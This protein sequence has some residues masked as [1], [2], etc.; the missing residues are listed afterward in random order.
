MVLTGNTL[1]HLSVRVTLLFKERTPGHLG[2]FF[3]FAHL[4]E[5][6][7]G[8]RLGGRESLSVS[9]RISSSATELACGLGQAPS[10]PWASVS[11]SAQ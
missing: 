9:S 10:P 8:G 7:G 2:P 5:R 6:D 1:V 3:K 4:G 11:L